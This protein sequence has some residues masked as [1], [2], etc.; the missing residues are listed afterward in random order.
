MRLSMVIFKL[1]TRQH[2]F[3]A[4]QY[5][6]MRICQF[7]MYKLIKLHYSSSLDQVQQFK[8]FYLFL[9]ASKL[10][11]LQHPKF[12]NF[13]HSYDFKLGQIAYVLCL[14]QQSLL[15]ELGALMRML[16]LCL[17]SCT[18]SLSTSWISFRVPI[19]VT[20]LFPSCDSI[21]GHRY[22]L[23]DI[24]LYETTNYTLYTTQKDIK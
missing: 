12:Y 6:N 18:T 16:N 23:G 19:G 24:T 22:T 10:G 14:C 21:L 7:S 15:S 11:Y 2:S 4:F 1:S 5:L 17:S 3:K 8:P 20:K 9:N 13:K